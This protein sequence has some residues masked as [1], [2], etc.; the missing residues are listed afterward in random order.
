MIWIWIMKGMSFVAE[1]NY[2]FS[3]T[4]K[5]EDTKAFGKTIKDIHF[6]LRLRDPRYPFQ[7]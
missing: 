6:S 3:W 4:M 2:I 5:I 1:A 7:R